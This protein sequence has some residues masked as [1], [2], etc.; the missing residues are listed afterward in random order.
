[1]VTVISR[2]R[3]RN[4]LEEEVRSAFLNR[5]RL[6]EKAAGFCGLEV[7][8]DAAD[9]SVFLLL[10]RWTDERSFREWHR[11]DAHHQS[12]AVNAAGIET[13]RNLHLPD[14]RKS[15]RESRPVSKL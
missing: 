12:H 3:V 1:M 11:S 13:G 6:V 9:P 7:L 4:G 14:D 2:F 8:T 10:T 5:P 15:H